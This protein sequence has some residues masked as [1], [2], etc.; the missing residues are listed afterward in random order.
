MIF[1]AL[2]QTKAFYDSDIK[3]GRFRNTGNMDAEGSWEEQPD[4]GSA[5]HVPVVRVSFNLI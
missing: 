2:F 1:K 3:N 4:M 5:V